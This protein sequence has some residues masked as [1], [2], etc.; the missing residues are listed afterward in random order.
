[1]ST[2]STAGPVVQAAP[3]DL[4]TVRDS[5]AVTLA[6]DAPGISADA[7]SGRFI[8]ALP[9]SDA[10]AHRPDPDR[11]HRRGRRGAAGRRYRGAWR[12][13]RR[14]RA[15]LAVRCARARQGSRVVTAA[16]LFIDGH[17][18]G[19]AGPALVSLNPATGGAGVGRRLG[20]AR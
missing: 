9:G 10:T 15:D 17:W 18:I 12:R 19:G 11:G 6:G 16:S 1:M 5:R 13:T 7:E 8:V 14:E 3:G 20:L 2:S 4:K